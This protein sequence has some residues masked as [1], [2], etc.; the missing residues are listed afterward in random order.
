[1]FAPLRGARIE[2]EEL[3]DG[4]W[5]RAK[6][7][8]WGGS[9]E[10]RRSSVAWSIEGRYF[11]N[12][13]CEVVCPCA[14]SFPLGA[15]YDRCRLAFVFHV[16]SG[17]VEGVDVSG[18]TLVIVGDA[19]KDM[20]QG[21]WRVGVLID[22]SA[23]DDQVE[24]LGA[25]FSGALGGPMAAVSGLIGE[26]LGAERIP[27]EFSSHHGRHTLKVDGEQVS[28]EDVVPSGAEVGEPARLTGLTYPISSELAIAKSTEDS[29]ISA[30]GI[31]FGGGGRSGFSSRFSWAG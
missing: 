12:C 11:E 15:D 29:G 30:F 23:S 5:R 4:G 31:T 26:Q 22:D 2:R 9:T 16:D 27:I 14:V 6:N 1:V 20:L 24:K 10:K 19:P 3:L 21:D 8:S 25:V 28:V 18:L 13:S 17:D 7:A